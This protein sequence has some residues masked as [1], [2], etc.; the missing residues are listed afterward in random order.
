MPKKVK[1]MP[2]TPQ[3]SSGV[4]KM[5]TPGVEKRIKLKESL[6]PDQLADYNDMSDQE[7]IQ[8]AKEDGSEKFIVLDGEG[9]LANREEL[10]THLLGKDV[11]D[12]EKENKEDMWGPDDIDP[13]GGRGPS[14]HMEESK[15]RS[16]I[17]KLIKEEL[18]E[19][20]EDSGVKEMPV[21]PKTVSGVKKMD[22]PGAKKTIKLKEGIHDRDIPFK[23]MTENKAQSLKEKIAEIVKEMLSED[24][25]INEDDVI[26]EGA[27][28]DKAA[29]DAARANATAQATAAQAAAKAAAAAATAAKKKEAEVKSDTNPGLPGAGG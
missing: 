29:A 6:S 15:V 5:K 11:N 14:S 2:V 23:N 7:I 1:E 26:D 17:A 4:K 18:N 10:L 12:N 13:A 22:M 28:E 16:L 8:W 19:Y 21:T 24:D 25:M 9:G 27:A 3:N 20:G